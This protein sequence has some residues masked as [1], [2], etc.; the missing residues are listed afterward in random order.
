M[1]PPSIV[2]DSKGKENDFLISAIT[3][4][5]AASTDRKR[6]PSSTTTNTTIL[7]EDICSD[8]V[9]ENSHGVT[10]KKETDQKQLEPPLPPSP[11]DSASIFHKITFGWINP[12]VLK[13]WR[14]PLQQTDLYPLKQTFR[15]EV[16]SDLLQA[17]WFKELLIPK[18]TSLPTPSENPRK[19]IHPS[20]IFTAFTARDAIGPSLQ[21]A[22]STVFWSEIAPIGFLRFGSNICDV[23]SPLLVK[24]LIEYVARGGPLT[25]GLGLCITL[26]ILQIGSTLFISHNYQFSESAGMRVKTS[27]TALIYRKTLRLS[28]ASRQEYAG[29]VVN[30]VST[31]CGRIEDFVSYADLLWTC[32]LQL[33]ILIGFLYSQ[34]G[35]ASLVG[36]ALIIVMGPL[37]TRVTRILSSVRKMVAPLADER[38]KTTTEAILG[39]RII[40]FFAWEE[41]FKEKIEAI[42]RRELGWVLKRSLYTALIITVSTGIPLMS[43]AFSF[44]AYGLTAKLEPGRVF[45]SLS[46]FNSL[47]LPRIPELDADLPRLDTASPHAIR[48][49]GDFTWDAEKEPV[50]EEAPTKKKMWWKRRDVMKKDAAKI[51]KEIVE[52]VEEVKEEVEVKAEVKVKSTLRNLDLKIEKGMLVA[53]VG[54]VG[55]GKSSLLEAIAGEMQKEVSHMLPKFHGFR[56]PHP[57]AGDQTSIGE[58]GINLSGGQKQRISLAR[59]VYRDSSIILLDDP[60]SAVDAGVG[61]HIFEK[62]VK[63]ALKGKTRVMVTHQLWVLGGA[64]WVIVMNAGEVVEQ[65]T[66]VD[67]VAKG[68][69]LADMVQGMGVDESHASIDSIDEP[70]VDEK[71]KSG[72]GGIMIEEDRSTGAVKAKVWWSYVSSAGGWSFLLGLLLTVGIVQMMKV[73]NDLWLVWWSG[74]RFAG[75]LS[76]AGYIGI[77][78][79]WGVSQMLSTLLFAS[80]FAYA[81]TRAARTLHSS[82]LTLGRILNRF[83]KDQDSIDNLLGPVFRI[84]VSYLASALATLIVISVATPWFLAAFVGLGIGYIGVQEVYRASSR[85]LKRLGAVARSPV[86]ANFGETVSGLS[87]IRAPLH[88]QHDTSTDSNNSPEFL[89]LTLQHWLSLRLEVIGSFLVFAAALFG[90]ISRSTIS[91]ALLGLSLTYALQ[92]T[93]SLSFLV[94]MYAETEV[95]MN[96]VERM[97]FYA[98]EVPVESSGGMD[99]TGWPAKGEIVFKGV[100]M[101]YKDGMPLVLKGVSFGVGAGEK[102][103]IVG[104]TGSGKS[105]L[106]Q[107]LFRMVEVCAGDIVVDGVSTQ[108]MKLK[109]LRTGLSIIPQDPILYSGTYRTNLDP[110][111]NYTDLELW[112][113]LTRAGIKSKVSETGLDGK[114]TDGGENLSVGQ[115]QL[116][117]L[118]R[119]MLKRSKIIVMDE[120]TANVD[121]ETDA[122]IQ[123]ALRED[124]ADATVLT[125]AHRINTIIDY[126][127][128]LVMDNG[129]VI[130]YDTPEALLDKEDSVFRAMVAE[131]GAG[132][133]ELLK[134]QVQRVKQE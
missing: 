36:L 16:L 87:T 79:G 88:P 89:L 91:P 14:N 83:S 39:I 134:S 133:F 77:Y 128:V 67:L 28:N 20:N 105:S 106:M 97:R 98:K 41:A 4:P 46:W 32:M 57:P 96:A 100:E 33:V 9:K 72:D 127:R 117:C 42:R 65:G 118:A 23:L 19:S 125:I 71:K 92:I 26:L 114:I 64:D 122:V 1:P 62:C 44:V 43:S 35:W 86:L 37:Q 103:G 30:L 63:E 25:E 5:T 45:A 132:N 53:V 102:V 66:Y 69:V 24:Y 12:L 121:Y 76:I 95:A 15:A 113:A 29:K 109:D 130:E 8:D 116:V 2:V 119:A 124:F 60:L 6:S 101:R 126:D 56:P 54:T 49:V 115:R 73:G 38:V 10:L 59:A 80:F 107:A 70:S 90:V 99:V 85:E 47:R 123:K 104:R 84:F 81:S 129:N 82:A 3:T 112:D 58:R 131:T 110:F 21:R 7:V 108:S 78:L 31:D 75:T 93:D 74:D 111:N 22:L 11:L 48:I 17:A 34:L 27:L 52:E 13:G 50:I 55:S 51:A 18:P 61:R 68:G 94:R 40:K 120:A